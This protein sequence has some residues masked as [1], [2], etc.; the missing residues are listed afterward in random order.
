MT[1][2][3][4]SRAPWLLFPASLQKKNQKFIGRNRG[5]QKNKCLANLIFSGRKSEENRIT[6]TNVL[7]IYFFSGRKSEE[8]GDHK[9]KQMFCEFN[10]FR[11]K[12]AHKHR[13]F[14]PV[15]L[16]TTP[17]MSRCPWD[18]VGLFQGQTQVFSL[19]YTGKPGLSQGQAQFVPG[20]IP[21]TKG[22]LKSLCV[23]SLCAF[24]APFFTGLQFKIPWE[25][26]L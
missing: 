5:S 17:G 21:G 23:K 10:F 26:N 8:T 3:S 25:L 1:W 19:F 9:K 24:F 16:G 4:P 18:K 6:K 7:R 13:L 20:T 11:K 15:A 2:S 12:K 22:G 14:G